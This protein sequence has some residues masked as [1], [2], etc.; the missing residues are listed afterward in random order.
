[1]KIFCVKGMMCHYYCGN[2]IKKIWTRLV[3]HVLFAYI[4]DIVYSLTI[5]VLIKLT[6]I[7]I[8]IVP[9]V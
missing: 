4:H 6:T 8:I 1:M 5:T 7:M 2:I 3:D 9:Y